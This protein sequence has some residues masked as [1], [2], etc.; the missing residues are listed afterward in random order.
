MTAA[1]NSQPG[2]A[3]AIR[4]SHD[5]MLKFLEERIRES[6]KWPSRSPSVQKNYDQAKVLVAKAHDARALP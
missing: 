6:D 1:H 4:K 5:A 2:N 3:R